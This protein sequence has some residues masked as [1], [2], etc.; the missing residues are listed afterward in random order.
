MPRNTVDP[1]PIES[2]AETKVSR[3]AEDK[4]VMQLKL[5]VWGRVGWPDR[6]YLFKGKLI[7]IEFKREGESPRKI[8]IYVHNLIKLQGF[9]VYVV[10]NV[11][12]G[13]DLVDRLTQGSAD[14]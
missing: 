3:Y 10:D 1:A 7:F 8:Q 12:Q 11:R 13:Y 5:N 2:V 4:G 14:V 9:D 6:L